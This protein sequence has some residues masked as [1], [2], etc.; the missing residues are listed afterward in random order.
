M[1]GQGL[2]PGHVYSGESGHCVIDHYRL[3]YSGPQLTSDEVYLLTHDGSAWVLDGTSDTP[4]VLSLTPHNLS[5]VTEQANYD[6]TTNAVTFYD[7]THTL[8]IECGIGGTFYAAETITLSWTFASDPCLESTALAINSPELVLSAYN[9][10]FWDNGT[11][12]LLNIDISLLFNSG[13]FVINV[14]QS[15]FVSNELTCGSL[16]YSY[17]CQEIKPNPSTEPVS[18]TADLTA[19]TLTRA[20]VANDWV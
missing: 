6:L 2:N 3:T 10:D 8:T 9:V 15:L 17:E 20:V 14:D 1:W 18:W 19:S 5:I 4:S 13:N 7:G 16:T 12:L 11:T